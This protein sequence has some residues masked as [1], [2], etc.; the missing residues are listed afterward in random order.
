MKLNRHGIVT[1]NATLNVHCKVKSKVFYG[2]EP[3]SGESTTTECGVNY[4]LH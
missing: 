4:K 2:L 3:P 1:T